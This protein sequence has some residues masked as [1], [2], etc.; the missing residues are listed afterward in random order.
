MLQVILRDQVNGRPG[1]HTLDMEWRDGVPLTPRMLIA[2]R[3]RL[4]WEA[5]DEA[6]EAA[7][8][9]KA[10]GAPLPLV[11]AE[12]MARVNTCR[13]QQRGAGPVTLEVGDRSR[14]RGLQPQC[15]LPD[16]RW[17]ADRRPR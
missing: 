6:R 9:A 8:E 16:R 11:D 3:V 5:R 4:E 12:M 2:E 15:L 13:L 14:D 1:A 17:A 7:R 10:N